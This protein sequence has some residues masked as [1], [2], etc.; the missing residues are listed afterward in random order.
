MKRILN[1][2]IK[3][4]ISLVYTL[5]PYPKHIAKCRSMARFFLKLQAEQENSALSQEP[6]QPK[7]LN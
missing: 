1:S 3:R 7:K 4:K 5:V 6:N 2:T